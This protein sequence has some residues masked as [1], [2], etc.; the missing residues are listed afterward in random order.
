M[1]VLP[2]KDSNL[3]TIALRVTDPL[4]MRCVIDAVGALRVVLE[5]RFT[6]DTASSPMQGA[7]MRVVTGNFVTAKP[8]GVH[9][10]IDYHYTGEVRRIDTSAINRLLDDRSLVLLSPMGY[11]PTG[12]VFNLSCEEVATRAAVALGAEKL[13]I[14]G[15]D[16]GLMDVGGTLVR[17]LKVSDAQPHL[18]R[19]S[20]HYVGRLLKA[21]VQA[22]QGGV[23]RCHLVSYRQDG[24]ILDELFTRDGIGT[25]VTQQQFETL[26]EATIDD[27]GGLL[28]LIRPLEESGALVRRSRELLEQEIEQFFII[29]RDGLLIGS[30]AL[31]PFPDAPAGELACLAVHP[32][33]REG[34]R[35]QDL[36]AQI[37]VSAREQGM[38]HLYV[39]TTRTAHWFKNVVSNR[40]PST[41]YRNRGRPCTTGSAT[42][43]CFVKSSKPTANGTL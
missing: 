43:K 15:S 24:A 8:L 39:L 33:Y 32:E 13:I 3:S 21:A 2:R 34:G 18:D 41:H 35:G 31:Y 27:V 19:L 5:A 23:D 30:A 17:Q 36:L 4:A 37:E 28:Q 38:S 12:E 26:R 10:G 14:C 7:R 6:T 9:D 29:E 20:E 16:T 11:S 25:L 42:L 22:C 1:P 40:H